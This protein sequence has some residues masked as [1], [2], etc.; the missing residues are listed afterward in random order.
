MAGTTTKKSL[1]TVSPGKDLTESTVEVFRE[2][3][4]KLTEQNIKELAIDMKNVQSM[5]STGLGV[6]IAA[7]NSLDQ[8]GGRLSLKNVQEDIEIF[9]KMMGL[10]RY[11]SVNAA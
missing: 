10:D 4:L 1:K 5:D 7:K 11:F 2:K 6:L 3:L 9:L 8:T